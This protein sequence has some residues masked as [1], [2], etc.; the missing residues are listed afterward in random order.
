MNEKAGMAA[1]DKATI[2]T[3]IERLTAGTPKALH[4]KEMQQKREL[5]VT[6]MLKKCLSFNDAQKHEM[7]KEW[8]AEINRMRSQRPLDRYWAHLDFDMFYIACELLDK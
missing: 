7:K 2:A 5:E 3:T 6:E 8:W 1:I 4:E